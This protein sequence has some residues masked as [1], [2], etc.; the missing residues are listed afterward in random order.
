M[1][2]PTEARSD[3]RAEAA[4]LKKGD[5]GRTGGDRN[6]VLYGGRPYIPRW[7]GGEVKGESMEA[8]CDTQQL[9]G[10]LSR[11]SSMD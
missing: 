7:R 3:R 6:F 4:W 8:R 10:M 9:G 5:I 11:E 2:M 1:H